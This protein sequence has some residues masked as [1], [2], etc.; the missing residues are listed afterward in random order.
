M[1]LSI[2]DNLGLY[3][4]LCLVALL[5]GLMFHDA[6]TSMMNAWES[7]EYSHGYLIPVISFWFVWSNRNTI[8]QMI[9]QGSWFGLFIVLIGLLFGFMGELASLYIVTQYAFLLVLY[10]L[11]LS[12][13]G[14]KGMRIMWFPLAYLFFMIP[15]PNFIY[16]NLSSQL[17]LISSQ[18]GVAVIRLMDISVFLQGNV[19][20]L[21]VY[22][23][24]VVEACSGLRYLFPL[25][26]FGFLCA[27]FFRAKLWMR[28]VVFLTTL[29]IT[30]VMN[31][32]RIGVIG[33]LVEYWGIEQAEGF[34]HDFEGWIIFIGCLAVLF[35]EMWLMVKLFMPGKTFSQ[36]F[37][38]DA[39]IPKDESSDFVNKTDVEYIKKHRVFGLTK[40][41]LTA[42]ILLL[43]FLP[44]S[45]LVG[46][47]QDIKPQRQRF[48]NFPLQ[49]DQWKGVDV[50]MAQEFI[51]AL[52]FDDYI[53]GNYSKKG[54]R[55]PINFYVA[56]YAS[57]RK[58][59]SAHSPK[60]CIPGD[61]WR[62]A[63]FEQRKIGSLVTAIG[64]QLRV[65]RTIISK[66]SSRQL[67]YYWFQQ[68]GRIITNEYLVKWYLFWD[69][70]TQQRTDGALVRLVVSLPEGSDE[71]E[72][73]KK[74]N[75]FLEVV[76]PKLEKFI[77]SNT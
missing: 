59:A 15:L 70:L 71:A 76:F 43:V 77:P 63:D 74:L 61:G 6:L 56:Y 23:L 8:G 9:G 50:G 75:D 32:F 55:A 72:A 20:D 18:L 65:N 67:V 4:S 13:V 62:I 30:V 1:N 37:I 19:I 47:R 25:T 22:K 64:E 52:K 46:E 21:G 39:T 11:C 5:S 35:A 17:Q 33:I 2:K 38:V 42:C 58:G 31:S 57:Q 44:F 73:D 41:Y 14:W 54:D 10:G 34:L 51:D 29:P 12:L 60:S 3:V 66:G 36:V 27:Y 68:R 45:I 28:A 16:N 48:A 24:Q 69:A 40:P 26:S 7:E 49:I 53:I